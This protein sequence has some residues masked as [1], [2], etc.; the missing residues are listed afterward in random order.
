[1][2]WVAVGVAAGA[3]VGGIASGY[4]GSEGA[5]SAAEQQ[6][7]AMRYS[8]DIQKQMFDKATALNQPYVDFGQTGISGLKEQLPYL[9]SQFTTQDFYNNIDPSYQ[10]RLSQGQRQAAQAAN[11]GGGFIGGNALTA[12]NDYTQGSAST[13]YQNA[14]TRQLQQKQNIYS[15]LYNIAAMGQNAASKTGT[16]AMQY[17]QNVGQLATA[18]GAVQAAGTMGATNAI[19]GGI[20]QA[21]GGLTNAGMYYGLTQGGGG[22]GG[23]SLGSLAYQQPTIG[24]APMG[25]YSNMGG[26]GYGIGGYTQGTQAPVT[27]IVE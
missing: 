12:L 13:E 4:L 27:Q 21:I 20:N 19:T 14:F 1:M 18:G 24:G 26:Q 11:V 25:G 16:N 5:K 7:A 17:G 22:G 8:A 3:A 10:W 23:T 6:A 9:T 2:T 15:S